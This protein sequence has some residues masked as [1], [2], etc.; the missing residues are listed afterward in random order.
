[1]NLS[2]YQNQHLKLARRVKGGREP[3]LIL[4][5]GIRLVTECLA[6]GLQLK[7][8]FALRS[9]TLAELTLNIKRTECPVYDVDE[10]L[11][12]SLGD[13]VSS[14]GIVLIAERP[15]HSLE[16]LF[17]TQRDDGKLLVGLD[18]VQDPGNAGTIVRTAEA[19]GA[20]GIVTLPGTVDPFSTK[21][22][23][24]SMGSAFRLPIAA[25]VPIE[26]LVR[27]ARSRGIRVVGAAADGSMVYSEYDWTTPTLLLLGNEGSGLTKETLAACDSVL[28]IPLTG[29][30]ESLNVASAAAVL[31]FEARRQMRSALRN[32]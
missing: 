4:V 27:S 3:R 6:S 1:M 15:S 20:L 5:E 11:I 22:L 17:V 29:S 14:Q 31:L 21:S 19:A 28:S 13:T 7:M 8:A 18:R 2:S 9:N 16:N 23:R 25:D 12:S 32:S 30:V 24:A 26:D 10:K